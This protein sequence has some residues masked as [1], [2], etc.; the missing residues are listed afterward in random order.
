MNDWIDDYT[1]YCSETTDAPPEYHRYVAMS[2]IGSLLGKK[3]F[4][5]L[6]DTEIYPN[7]WLIL[8]A[9][10]SLYRKSTSI[11][12]GCKIISNINRDIFYPPQ[13]SQEKILEILNEKPSGIFVFYEF[14]TFMK[15]LDRDYMAGTKSM[16]TELFDVPDYFSRKTKSVE[17]NIKKPCISILSATTVNWF[18][19]AIQ[20]QDMEGG[21]LPRFLYVPAQTKLKDNPLPDPVDKVLKRKIANQLYSLL[22]PIL[23]KKDPL[24]LK[25]SPESK[26]LYIK[27]YERYRDLMSSQTIKHKTFMVRFNI[28]LIKFSIICQALEGFKDNYIHFIAMEK[29]IKYINCLEQKI[30]NLCEDELAFTPADKSKKKIL[31]I[32]REG[33]ED[34]VKKSEILHKSGMLSYYLNKVLSSLIEEDKIVLTELKGTTKPLSIYK[35]VL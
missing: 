20:E 1:N 12:L 22:N 34:G 8:L 6:G 16:F 15:M 23:N 11:S 2:L 32:I 5:Q 21:F 27:W 3:V 31:K 35:I 4:F 30:I 25:M 26:K 24:C 13:F 33:K 19:E 18:L 29:A 28:Y 17:V 14:L 9:P 7:L 10:S